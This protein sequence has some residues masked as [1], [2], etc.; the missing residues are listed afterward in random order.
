MKKEYKIGI[1]ITEHNRPD[2]FKEAL[3]NIKKYLPPNAKL[4]IVDDAS[5][6]PVKEATYRFENNV[7]IARAKNKCLELLQD[8]DHIFLFDSDCWPKAKDWYLPYVESEEPHLMYIFKDLVNAKLNDSREL[9]R[10]SKI[11]AYSHPRGCMLYAHKSVLASAG[12]MDTNYKRWGFEH[13]DWSNRIYNVGL[14]RFRY[15]DV[16]DSNQLIY[17]LDEQMLVDSTVS[18]QE[19]QPYLNEM[20]PYFEKSFDSTNFAPYVEATPEIAGK[21]DTVITVYFTGVE[22]PQ[23][24]KWEPNMADITALINS[25]TSKGQRLVILHDVEEWTDVQIK[26]IG[27]QLVK[28]ETSLNPYFQRWVSIWDYLRQHPEIGRVWCVDA[29][30]VEML[31]NPFDEMESSKIYIGSETTQTWNNWMIANHRV[32]FLQTFFR[33]YARVA[34]VNPG[35]IGGSRKDV[36]ELLRKMNK[37]Y[38]DLKFEV[39]RY[40]MGLFNYVVR[41]F[42]TGRFETGAKVHTKFKGYEKYNQVAWWKHK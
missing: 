36:M 24:G 40:D 21:Q 10:D 2:V 33:Q 39:G 38:F 17:S 29:T 4:V 5:T 18:T 27:V 34:L 26:T 13:V 22:D 15:Q 12:G 37:M 7:G 42:F 3:K 25:V 19:R 41:T 20:R 16:P 14:T 1:G 30:D 11:V 8:C 35:V 9:Y 23:R 32:Q 6:V 28:V 31:R